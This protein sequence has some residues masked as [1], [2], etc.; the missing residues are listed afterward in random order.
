MRLKR[1]LLAS[2][3]ASCLFSP[4][5]YA[6]EPIQTLPSVPVS[7]DPFGSSE[8]S[9]ILAP[10]KI[11]SG[12]ELRNKI[13]GSLGDS[14]GQELGVQASG[15]S[16]GSS[17][18]VIR[19]LAGPRVK[20]LQNG[21]GSADLSAISSDH[22]VGTG[23]MTARQIEI[24][25]GPASLLY[26]S[27]A[28]GGL[29]NVINDRIPTQLSPRATAESELRFSS[30]NQ[31]SAL[32]LSAEQSSGTVGMHV[33]AAFSDAGDYRIPKAANSDGSG[34]RGRLSFS[35]SRE[36]EFGVGSSWIGDWGY[37][38][39]S[40]AQLG[41]NYALHGRDENAAIQ[42]GQLRLD[43]DSLF[44][45]PFDGIESMRVKFAHTDY[46][47]TELENGSTPSVRFTNKANE[48]RWELTHEPIDAWRGKF[49]LH[50]ENLNTQAANLSG[51]NPTVPRTL[52]T[53]I[54]GF[55][56]EE[57]E[58]GPLRLN[59]GARLEQVSRRPDS[60]SDRN[61]GL[62]ALSVGALWVF[63]PGY[64]LGPTVS[65]AQRAP[66]AEELYSNGVHHP[67]ETFDRGNQ[68]LKT[69]RSSN[70]ELTLQ[71]TSEAL[72]WRANLYQNKIQNFIYG[73]VSTGTQ[74]MAFDRD[75]TQGAATL[76]GFEAE[77]SYGLYQPGLS[78]R[79]FI[80]SSRGS[81]DQV[82]NLPLQPATRG[83]LSLGYQRAAWNTSLSVVH[84]N[85]QN[86]I[87]PTSI[88]AE[89]V[90]GSY[91]QLDASLSYVQRVGRW[92][93]TWFLLARNLLN[94][95]IRLS[96]SLLKDY[97]PQA[98]RNLVAGLRANF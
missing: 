70:L 24:L 59:A 13:N 29:V 1:F 44:K 72:R 10:A 77:L 78:G 62:G 75:F 23:L 19:G 18:P 95:E 64:A 80:D 31:G 5:G 6:N 56:V 73:S 38:G 82:G 36:S 15:F 45:R 46:E 37:V 65:M 26:G 39:A 66:S 55:A 68:S 67:T 54:A 96:T 81:L 69:E 25:R 8:T 20:I 12:D 21:M 71:K 61:F 85:A 43:V 30:V 63:M 58:F 83:G 52:S 34:E 79:I 33:D 11:L 49:G 88:S 17:R 41:K 97:V 84:A 32:G 53:S 90:T 48:A 16:A 91:T 47:H 60:G 86:R 4:I 51:G 7:A 50:V 42:M 57:R 2:V 89:T 98:G 22:A 93:L 94:Q 76:R 14:L 9:I 74:G 40:L 28:T 87:A 3:W 27:G 92:D 35:R